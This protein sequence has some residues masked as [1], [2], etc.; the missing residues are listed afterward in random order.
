[1]LAVV[2]TV[3]AFYLALLGGLLALPFVPGLGVPLLVGAGLKMVPE[4]ALLGTACRHVG[5]GRLMAYF[6]PAQLLHVPYIVFMGAVGAL[7]GYTWKGR[8]IAR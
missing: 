2:A 3:Y 4:A 7:G 1:M 5:R 8:R 6:L